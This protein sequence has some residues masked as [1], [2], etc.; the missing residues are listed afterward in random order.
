M[1]ILADKKFY[2]FRGRD[3]DENIALVILEDGTWLLVHQN[4]FAV[5]PDGTKYYHVAREV[6]ETP[7]SPDPFW[8]TDNTNPQSIADTTFEDLGWTLDAKAPMY[9][10]LGSDKAVESI[11]L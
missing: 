3:A 1:K 2:A 7:L 8:L 9:Y 10:P 11:I 4:G 6:E 5:A